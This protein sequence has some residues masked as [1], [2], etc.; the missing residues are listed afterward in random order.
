MNTQLRPQL[1]R[2]GFTLLELLLVVAIIGI[3]AAMLLPAISR[4]K[5]RARRIECNSG[6][7]QL[8]MALTMYADDNNDEFPARGRR[9]NT[10][11]ERLQP[12]YVTPK[13]LV[14]GS[15]GWFSDRSY[16]INGFNDWFELTLSAADYERYKSWQFPRGMNSLGITMPSDTIT[17]GEKLPNSR[18]IHMDF[19]QGMGNDVEEIDHGKHNDGQSKS[20]GANYSFADGSVRLLKYW[21]SLS[22][23]NLWAVTPLYRVQAVESN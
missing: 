17:F 1:R 22:P 8:N 21:G 2:T 19:Y 20:G 3:L 6:M 16:I 12:Y 5:G 11:I 18:Q 7:R 14:C 9:G 10:W 15:D 23:E 13:I 4:A